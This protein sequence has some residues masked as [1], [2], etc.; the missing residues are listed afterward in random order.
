M[1]SSE[2]K[3]LE[4]PRKR[5]TKNNRADGKRLRQTTIAYSIYL[6]LSNTL[7]R[8]T[9]NFLLGK[10]HISMFLLGGIPIENKQNTFIG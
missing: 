3:L 6:H 8:G 2:C 9:S 10:T 5:E 4:R 7:N 1:I